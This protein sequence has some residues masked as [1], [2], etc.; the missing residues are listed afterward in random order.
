MIIFTRLDPEHW[1]RLGNQMFQIAATCSHARRNDVLPAFNR[2]EYRDYFITRINDSLEH[3]QAFIE[4]TEHDLIA[5]TQFGYKPIPEGRNQ[6][7]LGFFQSAKYFDESTERLFLPTEKLMRLVRDA[8]KDVIHRTCPVA[9]HV[10][11]GDYVQKPGYH[12]TQGIDYYMRA[13]EQMRKWVGSCTF[14]V[15]SDDLEWCYENFEKNI[16]IVQKSKDIVD[17]FLMAQCRHHI[18]ANSSFSWWGAWLR[19]LFH[20]GDHIVI[21]PHNWA[22]PEWKRSSPDDCFTDVY[23]PGWHRI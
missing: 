14:L 19:R 22:G 13:M 4:G 23:L 7:L 5:H 10:R 1:G 12:P 3:E 15:F 6:S 21:A 18:I 20:N 8:G 16:Q 9:I 17:M 2:W 11:R